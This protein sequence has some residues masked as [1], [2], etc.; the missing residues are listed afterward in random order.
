MQDIYVNE[1]HPFPASGYEWVELYN[2]SENDISSTRLK[3]Y[4]ITNKS[5]KIN[6]LIIPPHTY[7]IA[8]SSAVLN[9]GGDTIVF[10]LDS[11]VSETITYEAI[12]QDKSYARCTIEWFSNV[13]PSMGV[14]NLCDTNPPIILPTPTPLPPVP[15]TAPIQPPPGTHLILPQSPTITTPKHARPILAPVL[16]NKKHPAN[17][18]LQN[19]NST[20]ATPTA[21]INIPTLHKD[22][23]L[24]LMTMIG[25]FSFIQLVFLVYLIIKRV[26][27]STQTQ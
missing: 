10:E 24:S 2:A 22:S 25:V 3:L 27:L 14:S 1:I 16:F 8:T 12:D 5:I 9:N 20:I 6:D 17:L 21:R 15:S 7:V 4:D 18:P 11:V 19:N 26:Q 13:A 23:P